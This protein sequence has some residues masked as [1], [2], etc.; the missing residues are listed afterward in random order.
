MFDAAILALETGRMVT[1]S[2]RDAA[3]SWRVVSPTHCFLC[4][5]TSL[6]KIDEQEIVDTGRAQCD[7]VAVGEHLRRE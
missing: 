4:V 1:N 7:D 3:R 6:P 5:N 2:R